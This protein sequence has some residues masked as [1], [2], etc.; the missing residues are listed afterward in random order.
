VAQDVSRADR[1]KQEASKPPLLA[2]LNAKGFRLIMVADAIVLWSTMA[3][4]VA[5][6]I[7]VFNGGER[8][9]L[10]APVRNYAIAFAIFTVIFIATYYFGGAYERELRLGQRA[11]LPQIASL[12]FGA[13]LL[14]AFLQ[15]AARRNFIPL[16][17]LPILLVIGVLLVTGN[18]AIARYLRRRRGGPPR[19]LLLGAPDEINLAQAHLTDD[20][21]RAIVVGHAGDARDLLTTVEETEATEVLLL[22]GRLLDEL[23]PEPL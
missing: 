3:A 5:A 1:V 6:R 16:P 23:Y 8:V 15:L 17:V 18:R 2:R 19:V 21:S 10:T 7:Y 11:A 22:S 14:V 12:S 4:V 13:W 20:E 9:R